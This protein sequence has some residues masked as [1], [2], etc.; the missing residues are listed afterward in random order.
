[1]NK[2]RD[3][4][5]GKRFGFQRPMKGLFNSSPGMK[6]VDSRRMAR[7]Q[8]AVDASSRQVS[9]IDSAEMKWNV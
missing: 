4:F 2:G 7:G 3:K 8:S 9:P 5:P 1:M 6:K